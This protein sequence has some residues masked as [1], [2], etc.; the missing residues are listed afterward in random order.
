MEKALLL[1]RF[2]VPFWGL[3]YLFG[4][5][6]LYWQ[7]LV[8][9]LG[10]YDR[11][12]TTVKDPKLLPEQLLADEK[13]SAI[14][15]ER[16]FGATTV[17]DAVRLGAATSPSAQTAD[18]TLAYAEFKVEALRLKPDYQPQTVNTDGWYQTR[19]AWLALCPMMIVIRCFLHAFLKIRERGQSS[20]LFPEVRRLVWRLYPARSQSAYYGAFKCF[21]TFAQAN[22]KGEALK[23]VRLFEQKRAELGRARPYPGG[24][25]VSTMLERHMQPM[26]RCL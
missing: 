2:G 7:R 21:V 10:R 14:N 23:A 3:S 16:R 6:D 25:R 19:R 9:Q 18:L 24:H 26:T 4:R 22:L 17:G 5:D 8:A 11:V 13:V 12:G 20:P 1:R 15:G